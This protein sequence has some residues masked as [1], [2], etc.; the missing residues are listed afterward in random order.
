MSLS[1]SILVAIL[2]VASILGKKPQFWDQS[3]QST[4]VAD[5]STLL[6]VTSDSCLRCLASL[7]YSA[8]VSGKDFSCCRAVSSESFS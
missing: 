1:L 4:H 7:D 8:L 2:V 5:S 6:R 3:F